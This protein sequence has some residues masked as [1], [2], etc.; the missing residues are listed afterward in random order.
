M[1]QEVVEMNDKD[2]SGDYYYV[3]CKYIT[4]NGVKIYPKNSK[5]FRLK[6]KKK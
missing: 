2:H 3:Y 4:K 6:V 5:A 1:K